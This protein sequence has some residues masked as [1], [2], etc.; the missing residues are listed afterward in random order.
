V[1][2]AQLLER[3]VRRDDP[4]DWL[5]AWETL[6]DEYGGR[7]YGLALRTL[8]HR[9]DAEDA[10][11]HV[12]E[13]VLQGLPRFRG[14]SSLSTWLFRITMNVCLTRLDART[15][16][17]VT[18]RGPS[19]DATDDVLA[20]LPDTTTPDPERRTLGGETLAAVERALAELDPVFRA[21]ILLR[22]V[23]GLRYE[24][25]AQALDIPVNTVKTRLHRARLELQAKL[26]SFRS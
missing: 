10:M 18:P 14:D 21:T 23:E 7:A 16:H 9:Q 17:T 6:V 26:A 22:E 15:R 19:D 3:L 8:R 1:N 4:D 12:W 2:E 5:D 13:R 25:I 20:Q 11:Q 24:E